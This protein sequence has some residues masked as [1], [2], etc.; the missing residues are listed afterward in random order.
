MSCVYPLQSVHRQASHRAAQVEATLCKG[1]RGH[2]SQLCALSAG[3]ETPIHQRTPAVLHGGV[4]SARPQAPGKAQPFHPGTFPS[5]RRCR[6]PGSA[7]G[8]PLAR[9]RPQPPSGAC[10]PRPEREAR[11]HRHR[12]AMAGSAGPGAPGRGSAGSGVGR[13]PLRPRPGP[14][15]TGAPDGRC[16][17]GREGG[18]GWGWG[19]PRGWQRIGVWRWR[20]CAGGW[21]FHEMRWGWDMLF[22]E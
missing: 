22:I 17:S 6:S 8:G 4:R 12:R 15:P 21:G 18:A 2:V 13:C 7:G 9:L 11:T 20:G 10:A 19:Y 14:A 5:H 16:S 3:G 1:C